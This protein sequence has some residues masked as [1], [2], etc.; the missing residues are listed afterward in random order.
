MK[1]IVTLAMLTL[2]AAV[3]TLTA[4]AI[5]C[6][7][8]GNMTS[9]KDTRNFG[10]FPQLTLTGAENLS[11]GTGINSGA[12]GF[13]SVRYRMFDNMGLQV[14]VK[15][16]DTKTTYDGTAADNHFT[17][18]PSG[19]I[20][21]TGS[22]T[23]AYNRA[24]LLWSM[25]MGGGML[26]GSGLKFYSNSSSEKSDYSDAEH[27]I[28]YMGLRPGLTLP[29]NGNDLDLAL[30][31]G[32]GSWEGKSETTVSN[33]TT[34]NYKLNHFE[35]DGWMDMAINAR[36][37]MKGDKIDYV[38]FAAFN[39]NSAGKKGDISTTGN[40][41]DSQSK[42]GFTLGSGIHL[43]PVEGINVFNELEFAYKNTTHKVEGS[44][45]AASIE[46]EDSK[47][48]FTL[49]P[50]YRAG[51]ES[52]HNLDPKN[53]WLGCEQIKFWGGFSKAFNSE[54]CEDK[55]S[56]TIGSTTTSSDS[57]T[58]LWTSANEVALTFGSAVSLSNMTWEFCYKYDDAL[59]S[60]SG[61]IDFV[62]N[63]KR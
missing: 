58:S 2:L 10:T 54:S 8:M 53:N 44:E 27:S 12:S 24:D 50:T 59:S 34:D 57:E 7:A 29:M 31:L 16:G 55:Y 11:I 38:P 13:G 46:T 14:N 32:F 18:S 1:K 52:I 17:V 35:N 49:L 37:Y 56:E 30:E 26:I 20:T 41:K 40:F 6:E 47:S 48:S 36:Y 19:D 42:L 33:T 23:E 4:G 15:T 25:D 21:T 5:R 51:V 45:T 62:Y 28:W 61:K 3:S 9:L 39:Y 60:S 43:R 22:L 63:F